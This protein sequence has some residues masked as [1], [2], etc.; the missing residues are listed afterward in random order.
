[1]ELKCGPGR[2]CP[3][4]S[5]HGMCYHTQAASLGWNVK[6]EYWK[7]LEASKK[8]GSSLHSLAKHGLPDSFRKKENQINRGK[9]TGK[10]QKRT[11][12]NTGRALPQPS[13]PD[14]G[15]NNKKV[16]F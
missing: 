6:E 16:M 9:S 13:V 3:N 2:G 1:M 15:S 7:F 5:T 10:T 14:M 11:N 8:V 12:R 4:F